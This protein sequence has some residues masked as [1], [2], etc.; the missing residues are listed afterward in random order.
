MLGAQMEDIGI[1]IQIGYSTG[2]R[3]RPSFGIVRNFLSKAAGAASAELESNRALSSVLIYFW[4]RAK[5]LFPTDVVDDIE[6]F[7]SQN[8]IPRF[9]PDWPGRGGGG[10]VL[11]LPLGASPFAFEEVER[12]PGCAVA[13]ADYARYGLRFIDFS[14]SR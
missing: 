1:L 11:E 4:L 5:G 14:I 2:L 6:N 8:D 13:V 3:N 7:Y 12:S 9:D 10:G